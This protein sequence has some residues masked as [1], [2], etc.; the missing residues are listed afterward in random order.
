MSMNTE[1]SAPA[2]ADAPRGAPL[3]LFAA[4]VCALLLIALSVGGIRL[5][6]ELVALDV[7]VDTQWQQVENQLQ[8]QHELIPKLAQVASRYAQHEAGVLEKLA[9]ARAAYAG[10]NQSERP[11]LA[12]EV[13]GVLSNVLALAEAYPDLKADQQFRDL[14]FEIAGTKN[15]IT[16]ERMRYN[17][18]VGVLN[19]RLRQ[20]PWSLVKG[21]IAAAALYEPPDEKLADPELVL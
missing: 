16:L 4:I 6:N 12:G 3:K 2:A 14:S 5:R 7:A 21:D 11:R 13:D 18:I 19:T 17:E 8:R 1:A 15:R 9:N 10:A 20:L